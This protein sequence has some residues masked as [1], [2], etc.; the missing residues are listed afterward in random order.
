MTLREAYDKWSKEEDNKIL[1]MRY[2]NAN[3][4]CVLDK[5][6]STPL[7]QVDRIFVLQLFAKCK[8]GKELK[9]K[10]ASAIVYV[11][12][13]VFDKKL[14]PDCKP[15]NYD[16]NDIMSEQVTANN[17]VSKKVAKVV[18]EAPA[19][20][21]E[22]TGEV[23][24]KSDVISSETSSVRGSETTVPNTAKSRHPKARE[25]AIINPET[26][27]VIH[28]FLSV[29]NA[30]KTC[31]VRNIDRY[32]RQR[33]PHRGVWWAYIDELED[34]IAGAPSNNNQEPTKKKKK[35]I[36]VVERK[37]EKVMNNFKKENTMNHLEKKEREAAPV[38]VAAETEQSK[39]FSIEDV[40][41]EELITEC[42]RRGWTGDFYIHIK[43]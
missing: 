11:M 34:W 22:E 40:S 3:K 6:G 38:S 24:M 35:V 14:I 42:R 17:S 27:E 1:A 4:R 13:Y 21:Y 7:E 20:V 36:T 43:L 8:E 9:A 29:S 19:P 39:V 23:K 33:K 41:T 25:V 32:C 18:S 30:E 26:K 10:A 5:Y 12:R 15:V 28:R 37:K 31:A 2:L 16:Y